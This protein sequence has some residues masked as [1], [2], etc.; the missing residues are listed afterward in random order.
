[1]AGSRN[2]S[3]ASVGGS[4]CERGLVMSGSV[5]LRGLASA[6]IFFWPYS[7]V[8]KA[9]KLCTCE[10]RGYFPCCTSLFWRTPR[11][12]VQFNHNFLEVLLLTH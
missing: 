9:D 12:S 1:M 6:A 7:P 4:V 10:H 8:I 11:A 5:C 2:V 3:V